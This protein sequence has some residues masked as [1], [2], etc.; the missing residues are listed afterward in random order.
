MANGDR[1]SRAEFD[2][3][4]QLSK[5]LF[6]Q[7]LGKKTHHPDPAEHPRHEDVICLVLG[8]GNVNK[9]VGFLTR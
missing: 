4:T 9:L 7:E 1:C 3:V 2:A 8:N 6:F 5:H